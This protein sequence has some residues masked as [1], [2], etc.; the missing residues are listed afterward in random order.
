M[1]PFKSE[2]KSVFSLFCI[3]LISVFLILFIRAKNVQAIPDLLFAED[4]NVFMPAAI[5]RGL[6]SLLLFYGGYSHLLMR[7][8]AYISSFFALVYQPYLFLIFTLSYIAGSIY[9]ILITLRSLHLNDFIIFITISV[10]FLQPMHDELLLNLAYVHW[11][12]AISFVIYSLA[13]QYENK[14]WFNIVIGLFCGLTGPHSIFL[15]P[16]LLV[17][18][19]F[20]KDKTNISLNITI[21]CCALFQSLGILMHPTAIS[22]SG[23]LISQNENF[24]NISLIMIKGFLFV[25]NGKYA[26]ILLFVIFLLSILSIILSFK[27]NEINDKTFNIII[28]FIFTI[29]AYAASSIL[30]LLFF[31]GGS[32]NIE[33]LMNNNRYIFILHSILILSSVILTKKHIVIQWCILICLALIS[34]L[35]FSFMDKKHIYYNSFLNLSRYQNVFVTGSPFGKPF[36]ENIWG[37]PLYQ[38]H[39]EKLSEDREIHI[40]QTL[41]K[42]EEKEERVSNDIFYY[43]LR[44]DT[45]SAHPLLVRTFFCPA[46]KDLAFQ[47]YASSN[48]PV[49]IKF[50]I[51]SQAA[52]TEKEF[53]FYVLNEEQERIQI[54]FPFSGGDAQINLSFD[55]WPTEKDYADLGIKNIDN[56]VHLNISDIR[57]FCLP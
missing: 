36:Y 22:H 16:V 57:F 51:T 2:K 25:F 14:K 34:L 45:T 42:T 12:I 41:D 39:Y 4:L 40:T 7:I 21:Y 20:M 32:Y 17:K 6:S 13:Y 9:I 35:N 1:I 56:D 26:T 43:H 27:K 18:Q 55:A 46:S 54:A 38:D 31:R 47:A 30:I 23:A 37:L 10:L 19:F 48:Y 8:A 49:K 24:Y 5:Y 3:S 50:H 33:G 53:Y 52:K 44:K 28:L 29:L 11:F 15:T